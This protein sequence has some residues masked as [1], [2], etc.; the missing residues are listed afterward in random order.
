MDAEPARGSQYGPGQIPNKFP[1]HLSILLLI[2]RMISFFPI[3][4][5][6]G[7]MRK[8]VMDQMPAGL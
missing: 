1:I 7:P 3:I 4:P 8:W 2:S 6:F 5:N